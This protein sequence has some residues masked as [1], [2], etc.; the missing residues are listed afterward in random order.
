MP[1]GNER[2]ISKGFWS[3][4]YTSVLKSKNVWITNYKT[5]VAFKQLHLRYSQI[6]R[7]GRSNISFLRFKRLFGDKFKLLNIDWLWC[8]TFQESSLIR[9]Y[10][11]IRE[12]LMGL[13]TDRTM[14]F[15]REDKFLNRC[16]CHLSHRFILLHRYPKDSS[17]NH[18]DRTIW[19]LFLK[20]L[21]FL[22]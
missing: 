13:F 11:P 2:P 17:Q 6:C 22:F 16:Q 18:I 3:S 5:Q 21:K 12:V 14:I 15:L 9:H 8:K 1:N 10:W 20:A 19:L 7:S 4:M